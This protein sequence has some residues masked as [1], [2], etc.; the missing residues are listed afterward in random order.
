M[1]SHWH[2]TIPSGQHKEQVRVS[3]VAVVVLPCYLSVLEKPTL[4]NSSVFSC[5]KQSGPLV[6]KWYR[7]SHAGRA[8]RYSCLLHWLLCQSPAGGGCPERIGSSIVERFRR[9]GCTL[10]V[11]TVLQPPSHRGSSLSSCLNAMPTHLFAEMLHDPRLATFAY[12]RLPIV[13]CK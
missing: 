3:N 4:L 9:R 10:P 13:N 6:Y 5:C 2:R 12:H 7:D 1:H 8:L 11:D